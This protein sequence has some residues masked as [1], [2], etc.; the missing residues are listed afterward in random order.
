MNATEK[1]IITRWLRFRKNLI[2]GDDNT[3]S[4][5]R[6]TFEKLIGEVQSQKDGKPAFD[7][8]HFELHHKLLT[9]RDFKNAGKSDMEKAVDEFKDL[10]G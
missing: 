10:F 5:L 3:A 7:K 9:A 8:A 2:T 6:L 4:A 1:R